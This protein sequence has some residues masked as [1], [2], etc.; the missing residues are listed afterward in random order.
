MSNIARQ[1]EMS[2]T[3]TMQVDDSLSSKKEKMFTIRSTM[4]RYPAK[5][6]ATMSKNGSG[7]DACMAHHQGSARTARA[8]SYN[9]ESWPDSVTNLAR[10]MIAAGLGD[11]EVLVH[12][13]LPLT[14]KCADVV[15]SGVDRRTGND[16]YVI[17][18][19]KQ[20]AHAELYEDNADLVLVSGT[21]DPK[22]HPLLEVRGYCDYLADSIDVL[23]HRRDAV[24]G[25]AY[26]HNAN[27]LDI[28]DLYNLVD[29]ER[30]RLFSQSRRGQF[31]D[32]LRAQFAPEP[33]AHAADRLLASAIRPSKQLLKVAAA[34]I[35][36]RDQFVLL[37]QQRL[38]YEIVLHAVEKARAAD[39][40]EVVIV[41][42]GPG[43][44]KSVIALSLLGE[45]A[46]RGYPAHHATGSRS[47]TETMRR[48]VA[49]GST[50]TKAMF[51]YFN[52]FMTAK[53]NSLD[54]LIC[55]EAH[56]IR[57]TS[58][59]RFTKA[60]E[61]TGRSQLDELMSAARVPVF[62]LDEHQVVRPG[63]TGTVADIRAHAQ[64][65][66][67]AVHQ[68]DLDGQF[69]CG[70]S[71]T[72]EEWVLRLLGL[73]GGDPEHWTGD[74]HFEVLLAESP[75]ELEGLLRGK[76]DDGYSARMTAGFCWRWSDPGDDTL[77]ADVRIDG[78][79]KPWNVKGDRPV[80]SAP[81]SALWAAMPGGFDQVG[82]VYTAQG[83]EY[84]WN[85]VIF[86]P[87][88]VYRDGRLTTVRAASKDPALLKRSV[89]D[90]EADRLIRNTY[91]VLLTRGMMGTV[92]YSADTLTQQF[93]SRLLPPL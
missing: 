77:V 76:L 37:D 32:Y 70:G 82:S 4:V 40:K 22:L 81:P 29:D 23:E 13:R 51:K 44:G 33:G 41:T 53:P 56:R 67:L 12:Y 35:K 19:L 93:F 91:K 63:E 1:G 79:S 14:N 65:R 83:F 90:E 8:S 43:S 3:A 39:S 55:D 15:L 85:G 24:R 74:D 57:E 72:Y 68:V 46:E 54:V 36:H 6:L 87:D 73:D 66:G 47:F 88:L 78:W 21:G 17:V 80:S 48:H 75:Y 9:D 52:N 50:R 31:I 27:D 71:R 60:A 2:P 45:L 30:T 58:A 5:K 69:R 11:I 28:H 86:G 64:A 16:A 10:D 92:L 49:R 26:L 20:W 7:M 18:Q 34:E 84:D 89:S 62:L 61:R 59:N 38:A 42:G 25:V